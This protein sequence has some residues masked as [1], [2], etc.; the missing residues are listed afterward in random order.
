MNSNRFLKMGFV[1][2]L[3]AV[4]FHAQAV[5]GQAGMNA[6][7]EAM[8][9]ELS[10]AQGAPMVFN[11]DP[12][13]SSMKQPLSRREVIHLDAKDPKS[14]EVVARVDCVINNRAEVKELIR[15]PLD[16]PDARLRATKL[17]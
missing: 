3:A 2:T 4:P 10:A 1:A 12:K 14:N 16:G 11:M 8:I 15:V 5:S 13:S 6:C 17:D 9:N 7:A